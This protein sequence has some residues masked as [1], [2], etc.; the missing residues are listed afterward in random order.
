M[1]ARPRRRRDPADA[2]PVFA[3]LGD[4][5]R[6]RLLARLSEHGPL[7]VVRL[8]EGTGVTR[9]AVSKHLATLAGAGLVSG[10]RRGREH[11]WRLRPRRLDAARRQLDAIESRWDDAIAR[12]QALVED[13][14]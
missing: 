1:S 6:L 3:A 4:P 10:E 7:P 8:A 5:V 12:L 2:A 13:D 11:V 14:A 9:Q